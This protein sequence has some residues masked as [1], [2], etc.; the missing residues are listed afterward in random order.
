M[1]INKNFVVKNGLEVSTDLLLANAETGRVGIGTTRPAYLLE[2]QGGIGVTDIYSTGIT[3]IRSE[4][5]V[6][7]VGAAGTVLS[8]VS[9]PTKSGVGIGTTNPGYLLDVR[10]PVSVGQTVLYV[11]GDAVFTGD[12]RVNDIF[13]DETEYIRV[14]G[15]ITAANLYVFNTGTIATGIITTLSGY[16]LYYSGIGTFANLNTQNLSIGSTQVISSERQLQNISSIDYATIAAIQAGI[17]T[18]SVQSFA[19]LNVTGISTLG[20][21]KISS[22]IVTA[23][24]GIVTYYG[25]GGKLT[26]TRIGIGSEG[27]QVSTSGTTGTSLLDFKTTTGQNLRV[28][29]N[30]TTGITTVTITP[31]VSLGLAIALGG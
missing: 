11:K 16:N 21:V 1:A 10:G 6:G 7:S 9:T 4:L 15:I 29:S 31:G 30:S 14:S 13:F 8:A 25:D 2:V 17:G 19:N 12:V 26:G 24:T 3:T 28:D 23:V 5:R 20:T 18:A 22:G 27:T